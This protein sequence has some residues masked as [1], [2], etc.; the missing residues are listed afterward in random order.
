M[1]PKLT[2]DGWLPPGRHQA[3]LEEVRER[4]V[5]AAPCRQHRELVFEGLLLHLKLLE[6]IGGPGRVWVNGGFVTHKNAPPA[7]ADLVYLCRDWQHLEAMLDHDG[8]Y[9]LLTLQG[10]L[11]SA[12]TMVSIRRIQPVGGLVDAFLAPPEAEEY[13]HGLWSRVKN[14][15]DAVKG[16]VEVVI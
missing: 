13:W 4:F 14:V 11:A 6:R 3:D 7:D 9:Q 16:Y 15:P 10:V 5:A 12:P 1:L 2:A 8:I